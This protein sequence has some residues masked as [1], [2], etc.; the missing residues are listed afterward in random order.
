MNDYLDFECS[1]PLNERFKEDS[2]CILL[3]CNKCIVAQMLKSISEDISKNIS[4]TI[5]YSPY[6]FKFNKNTIEL[7]VMHKV[8]MPIEFIKMNVIINPECKS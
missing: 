7:D 5:S 1:V 2:M 6:E 3:N 8:Q 4:Q